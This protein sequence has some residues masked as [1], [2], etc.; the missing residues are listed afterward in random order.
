M[1]RLWSK[2][3]QYCEGNVI[4]PNVALQAGIFRILDSASSDSFLSKEVSI[5]YILLII[6]CKGK[7]IEKEMQ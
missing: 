1:I 5:N 7:S 4:L 6:K 2:L 3:V